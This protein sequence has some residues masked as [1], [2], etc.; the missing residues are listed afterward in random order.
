MLAIRPGQ[1]QQQQQGGGGGEGVALA[2][3]CTTTIMDTQV[4]MQT[5]QTKAQCDAPG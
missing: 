3:R 1:K 2:M 4:I 5:V